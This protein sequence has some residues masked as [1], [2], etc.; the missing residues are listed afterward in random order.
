M[1]WYRSPVSVICLIYM[2]RVASGRFFMPWTG[3]LPDNYSL[4]EWEEA[5]TYILGLEAPAFSVTCLR[6]AFS[7][8]RA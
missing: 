8:G 5:V 3:S 7:A 1:N 4:E 2:T 6:P